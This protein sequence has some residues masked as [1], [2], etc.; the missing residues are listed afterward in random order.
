M[1]TLEDLSVISTQGSG[2]HFNEDSRSSIDVKI[3]L[4]PD[5]LIA[6][7]KKCRS[8]QKSLSVNITNYE[9]VYLRIDEVNINDTKAFFIEHGRVICCDRSKQS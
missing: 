1:S 4:N 9:G 6:R 3:T 5:K 7:M 8:H 2:L